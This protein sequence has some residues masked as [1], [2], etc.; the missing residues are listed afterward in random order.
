MLLPHL[1]ADGVWW[2]LEEL[3]LESAVKP[4]KGDY[5]NSSKTEKRAILMQFARTQA[6]TSKRWAQILRDFPSAALM[7]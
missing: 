2:L 7:G 3:Y 5:A 6:I 4:A 1:S